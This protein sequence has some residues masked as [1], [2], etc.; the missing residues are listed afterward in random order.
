MVF[1]RSGLFL[2]HPGLCA[3][4]VWLDSLVTGLYEVFQ[5]TLS[6]CRRI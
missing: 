6:L 1:S 2:L 4:L 3:Y 5:Y